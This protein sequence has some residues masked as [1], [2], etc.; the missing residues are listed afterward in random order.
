MP[1]PNIPGPMEQECTAIQQDIASLLE[2]LQN[3][4][5][6]YT[7][8]LEHAPTEQAMRAFNDLRRDLAEAVLRVM[9]GMGDAPADGVDRIHPQ[10]TLELCD[11]PGLL[12]SEPTRDFTRETVRGFIG[13]LQKHYDL[14]WR[15]NARL[16]LRLMARLKTVFQHG[17]DQVFRGFLRSSTGR[18]IAD[19]L[20]F[21]LPASPYEHQ[22]AAV[23]DGL[24]LLKWRR[25]IEAAL[26]D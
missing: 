6:A 13:T 18:R 14:G 2:L 26:N 15:A 25:T 21:Y 11:T 10:H 8:D 23:I 7:R 19:H 5:D 12:P 16:A 1:E 22:I 4:H 3:K 17:D 24:P 9:D 20:T